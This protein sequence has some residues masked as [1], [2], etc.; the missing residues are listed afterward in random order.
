MHKN[1][2]EYIAKSSIDHAGVV[3]KIEQTVSAFNASGYPAKSNITNTLG[4]MGS[5]EVAF[6]L[7]KSKSEFIILRSLSYNLLLLIPILIY[8][9]LTGSKL[10]L[11]IP[12]PAF[13]QKKEIIESELSILG[14]LIRLALLHLTFPVV[15]W[16]FNRVLQYAPESKYFMLG[17]KYKTNFITNGIDVSSVKKR[18]S[19][20]NW[21]ST[22]FQLIGVGSL[23][24][25]HGYDRIL[26]SIAVYEKNVRA[27][28]PELPEVHF[29]IVGEGES[30]AELQKLAKSLDIEHLI[31]FSGYLID[32]PLDFAYEKAH[33]GVATL[34]GFRKSLTV[35]SELK[36]R[37]Y[38]S[39]G[40]PFI[41]ALQDIDFGEQCTFVKH[42]SN[43]DSL[44]DIE[45]LICWYTNTIRSI[46]MLSI[47]EYAENNLDL[48]KKIKKIIDLNRIK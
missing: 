10:I 43:D 17:C 35:A 2:I 27:I 4:I 28:K 39:K 37:E 13:N 33:V 18:A 14:K 21:P 26:N 23:A 1:K 46:S 8:K 12:T 22:K 38:T 44:F 42:V 32:G 7:L 40:L 24:F 19:A 6:K 29:N 41:M 16:F 20:P 34:A 30:L 11:D 47:R 3:K 31:E 9:R 45:E 5:V 36:A 25:W 15:S 48:P